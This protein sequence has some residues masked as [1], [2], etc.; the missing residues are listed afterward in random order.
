MSL[1]K[2]QT[3]WIFGLSLIVISASFAAAYNS[4]AGVKYN[5]DTISVLT[6]Q[7]INIYRFVSMIG[8]VLFVPVIGVSA[9]SQEREAGTLDLVLTSATHPMDYILSKISSAFIVVLVILI[10]MAPVMSVTFCMGGVSP[11]DVFS[12]LLFQ[13][14][15]TV[16]A[17]AVSITFGSFFWRFDVALVVS[18]GIVG[19]F[20]LFFYSAGQF[21]TARENMA[22][23]LIF[24]I[25]AM[26]GALLF[27]SQAP[28]FLTREI[29]K[30]KPKW[31][32]PISLKG[33]DAQLWT[34]LG[35]REYGDPIADHSNPIYVAERDRFFNAV[36]RR[37]WDVPSL[38]FLSSVLLSI[39]A[40]FP[41]YMLCIEYGIILV[42]T[43]I[44]GATLF[45]SEHER[46]N[47]E[48]LRSTLLKTSSIFWGKM[49]LAVG[50]GLIHAYS[51]YAPA[52][53]I[54]AIIWFTS[55]MMYPNGIGYIK[56]ENLFRVWTGH[57]LVFITVGFT[58][59]FLSALSVM[60][61]TLHKRTMPALMQSYGLSAFFLFGPWYFKLL[62]PA[63]SASLGGSGD[64]D[65]FATILTIW[66]GPYVFNLWPSVSTK[67]SAN[68]ETISLFWL[69]FASHILLLILL[70]TVCTMIG[71][72]QIHKAQD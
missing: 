23:P 51:F 21:G 38:L 4:M 24:S 46:A 29:N 31:W 62:H 52:L 12:V 59:L 67:G 25:V 26:I 36:V 43:P 40:L 14:I 13:M 1:R 69:M 45:S 32:R 54:L 58:V 28:Q 11:Y 7:L 18:Y 27:L 53:M 17:L 70:T 35:A 49:R 9:I 41:Q 8:L 16:F 64:M 50:H 5:L 37:D 72:K 47:W 10:G 55:Y 42:F 66:N 44:V 61:S 71:Y 3:Y 60:I 22:L 48:N 63:P 6:P 39:S 65:F 68:F 33:F 57:V 56:S 30:T 15:L 20:S 34:F 2:P 19:M